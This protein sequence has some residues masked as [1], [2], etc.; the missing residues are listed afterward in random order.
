MVDYDPFSVQAMEDP[1]ELY[2]ELREKSPVHRLDAYDA[3]AVSRFE[4]VW[5]AIGETASYT[6]A[7]GPVFVRE[8]LLKPFDPAAA[9]RP[10]PDRSFSMCDPPRLTALR[11]AISPSFRLKAMGLG[12]YCFPKKPCDPIDLL[13]AIHAAICQPDRNM[14]GAGPNFGE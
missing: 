5:Q 1:T 13:K 10:D 4:D 14:A 6:I 3:W 8:V 9:A 12:A 7:E 11:H 2:R